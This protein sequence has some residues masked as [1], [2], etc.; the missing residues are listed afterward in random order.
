MML[1]QR[2]A[3]FLII[4]CTITFHMHSHVG[5]IYAQRGRYIELLMAMLWV[6]CEAMS[7]LKQFFS[8]LDVTCDCY[9][10]H[11]LVHNYV[12]FIYYETFLN[13]T[14]IHEHGV[15]VVPRLHSPA[16]SCIHCL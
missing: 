8:P 1:R 10:L 13:S 4:F 6:F 15:L 9:S 7:K 14:Q 12:F 11:I 3:I 5:V 2:Y 16:R